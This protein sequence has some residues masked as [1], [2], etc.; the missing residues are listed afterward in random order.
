MNKTFS[1]FVII[2]FGAM[3][4][5]AGCGREAETAPDKL[6]IKGGDGQGGKAGTVCEKSAVVELLGPRRPGLLGGKGT[7][8]PVANATI[9]FEPQDPDSGLEVIGEN[10]VRTDSGG[11][12]RVQIKIGGR[13]GDQYLKAYVEDEPDIAV[14][15]R[16]VSGV[17]RGGNKQEAVAGAMLDRPLSVTVTG[18]DG[19]PLGGVPVYFTLVDKPGKNGSLKPIESVTNAEGIARANFETDADVTGQYEIL[20]EVVDHARGLSVRGV[21]FTVMALNRTKLIVGVLG[22]LGIFILGMKLMSDGLRQVAGNRLKSFLHFFTQNRFMAVVAGAVATGLI[23]SSSACTVMVVGFVNAGLISLRQAIG[24]VFGANIGTTVTAQMISLNIKELALPAVAVGVAISMMARRSKTRSIAYSILGFGLLFLGMTMMSA[25]LKGI[26]KFPSFIQVFQTFDCK[27]A[28]GE[29]M[30]L[31][32][33]LGAIAVG[34]AMTVVV[35]SSSATIGLAIALAGSGLINFYT[36]V[37]LILG[38]NIG[39]TVTALLASIGTNRPA[40]QSAIAHTIFNVLG[41]TYMVI[42]LYI[43]INGTPIFLYIVDAITT[44]D[45][46]TDM[47][48]NIERHIAAAHTLFNVF[49]VLLFLPLVPA[50]ALLCNTVLPTKKEELEI[51]P[52]EPHLLDTPAIAIDQSANALMKMNEA[53]LALTADCVQQLK[54]SRIKDQEGL[55][56]RE[57]IIDQMQHDTI[58]YLTELTRRSLSEDQ[59]DIIPLLVHCVNDAERIGDHAVNLLELAQL[60]ADAKEDFSDTAYEEID[61]ILGLIRKQAEYV[62]RALAGEGEEASS[63]ALKIEGEINKLAHDAE[64]NHVKRLEKGKCSVKS[65][66]LYTEVI[67]NLER[68]GDRFANIAE[69]TADIV[70]YRE[71]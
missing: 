8:L 59:A 11:H 65:G 28:P 71:A 54:E 57:D 48:E 60:R 61:R 44:G 19:L 18:E 66:I 52:L 67:A 42:L 14:T 3:L 64:K 9:V 56:R 13:F 16:F 20:A 29:M 5:G 1:A 22:G 7:R 21:P 62:D 49:N 23:Q 32:R 17:V 39:T 6:I 38:D 24:V 69:R 50:I 40:R 15:F 51:V 36:A 45:V 31:I 30:P 25:E 47:P 10:R 34:T 27:P 33:I 2:M 37:P 4:V 41:A 70:R 55:R 58:H 46:L 53:G 12:A 26:A 68:I 43:P 63:I 35:Q